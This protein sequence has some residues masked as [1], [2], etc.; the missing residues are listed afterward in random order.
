MSE[1]EKKVSGP[2]IVDNVENRMVEP[3]RIC[4]IVYGRNYRKLV[5]IV[6]FIDRTRLLVDGGNGKLS[7][8]KRVSM[9]MR[10]LQVTKFRLNIPRCASSDAVAAATEQSDVINE[11]GKSAMGRRNNSIKKKEAL[12]D[13]GRFKLYYIK[14][15]FKKAVARELLKLRAEEKKIDVKKLVE[16]KQKRKQA[17]PALRRVV[18]RFRRRL[19]SN[20][21]QKQLAR[22]RRLRKY[23]FKK[24]AS[25]SSAPKK[26]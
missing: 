11:F 23:K 13:F 17:H 15:Q 4:M 8:I 14:G 20:V 24:Q 19:S 26:D 16:Q 10:W 9:P 3:G 25:S 21:Y 22:K 7:A 18:G 1:E 12:N 6:D 2:L 5:C